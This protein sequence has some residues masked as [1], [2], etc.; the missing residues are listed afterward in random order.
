MADPERTRRVEHA[1][2]TK[3]LSYGHYGT[4][5]YDHEATHSWRFLRHDVGSPKQT[6]RRD[7]ALSLQ[8]ASC[9][10]LLR[11]RVVKPFNPPQRNKRS[12]Q[13]RTQSKRPVH[14][15][16]QSP[17]LGF[18]LLDLV[19]GHA[20]T[21]DVLSDANI[22]IG[23]RVLS[24]GHVSRRNIRGHRLGSAETAITV[25]SDG[26]AQ[27][28]LWVSPVETYPVPIDDGSRIQTTLNISSTNS[29]GLQHSLASAEPILQT[30]FS[31]HQ[32]MLG[33][34]K[35]SSITLLRPVWL[36]GSQG[37]QK[38]A[39]SNSSIR[40]EDA[41]VL[42]IS[43]T[44]GLSSADLAFNPRDERQLA[45]VDIHGV[46]SVWSLTDKGRHSTKVLCQARLTSSGRLMSYRSLQAKGLTQDGWH[47]L[48]WLNNKNE[49]GEDL[50]LVCSRQVAAVFYASGEMLGEVDMR[51]GVKTAKDY[52]L[53]IQPCASHSD[54]CFVLTS[55]RIMVMR[56]ADGV[57]NT[58]VH[59]EPLTMMCSWDHFRGQQDLTLRISVLE[60]PG[61]IENSLRTGSPPMN[62]TIVHFFIFSQRN[63]ALTT[64]TLRI[65]EE[66]LG[67]ARTVSCD[68]PSSFP[69][70][71]VLLKHQF[72]ISDIA[73]RVINSDENTS[74]R[75]I[76]RAG[77]Y[78]TLLA[79]AQDGTVL[80]AVYEYLERYDIESRE[81]EERSCISIKRE[82]PN[83]RF[84]SS[85][86]VDH[87]DDGDDGVG[88]FIVEDLNQ[89]DANH[90]SRR[91]LADEKKVVSRVQNRIRAWVDILSSEEPDHV[92]TDPNTVLD[93][94][95]SIIAHKHGHPG[96]SLAE[97]MPAVGSD[98]VEDTSEA[99]TSWINV[100][101][102]SETRT[103]EARLWSVSRSTRS[104]RSLLERY[105][106]LVDNYVGSL[107]SDV[108][109]RVRVDTERLSRA[110]ALETFLASYTLHSNPHTELRQPTGPT[111]ANNFQD[112]VK[113]S[114]EATEPT[115]IEESPLSRLGKYTA[116]IKNASHVSNTEVVTEVLGHLPVDVHMD[117]SDYS[118]ND[119]ELQLAMAR[120][121]L[122]TDLDPEA[123]RHA[124]KLARY[125]KKRLERERRQA[126]DVAL[127]QGMKPNQ[128][129]SSQLHQAGS[130]QPGGS[131]VMFATQPERG[132]FG[133]RQ[134][135]TK[136]GKKRVAG[137]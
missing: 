89:E 27:R 114:V 56:V 54:I 102:R 42:P 17:N 59:Q 60:V 75:S 94:L 135:M 29:H 100:T 106:C 117:P 111:T 79:R 67:A 55:M 4:A 48:C 78:V 137:F 53:D 73:C 25:S 97:V 103:D 90:S 23:G 45:V 84:A 122:D 130:S 134:K 124:E 32:S 28:N 33:V 58:E 51:I 136:T 39:V 7:G 88:D 6:L 47:R 123:K 131:Q 19:D 8:P 113:V 119:T 77:A 126:E 18:V 87:D 15:Y 1:H 101:S 24:C 16:R 22:A 43:R 44:G 85:K 46:W 86:Y 34:R 91:D 69:L 13:E 81:P 118:Y 57:L 31:R 61:K 121:R 110:A 40:I 83:R 35:A 105:N 11:S 68:G 38:P 129:M 52:I 74:H 107:P 41:L 30:S 26:A 128:V 70:P 62:T 125:E 92:D 49:S 95:S 72:P 109:D 14:A 104:P 93:V 21:Q 96:S 98:D 71:E 127:Q 63:K 99:L 2:D 9:F 116:V 133:A 36:G 115:Q 76:F 82:R 64:H 50:L 10:R 5:T 65:T 20:G 132:I 108:S 80:E 120:N 112:E 12:D 3:H 66:A 37:L